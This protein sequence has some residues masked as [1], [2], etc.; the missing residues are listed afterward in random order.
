MGVS[1]QR[2]HVGR[3]VDA[4]HGMGLG[5]NVE[6]VKGLEWDVFLD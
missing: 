3:T 6:G 2:Q 5:H 4:H 1:Q